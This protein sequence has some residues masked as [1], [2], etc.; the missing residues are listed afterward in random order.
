[1]KNHLRSI[2]LVFLVIVSFFNANAIDTLAINV[3]VYACKPDSGDC[4]FIVWQNHLSNISND[5]IR[6]T[7]PLYIIVLYNV[8][9]PSG[10]ALSPLILIGNEKPREWGGGESYLF[11]KVYCD[12]VL[13]S[14]VGKTVMI[15]PAYPQD[16]VQRGLFPDSATISSLKSTVKQGVSFLPSLRGLFATSSQPCGDYPC[17]SLTVRKILDLNGLDTVKVGSVSSSANGR[18]SSLFLGYSSTGR[19]LPK[20]LTYIPPEI[21]TLSSLKSLFLDGNEL[22]GLPDSIVHLHNLVFLSI[23]NNRVTSLPD[24]I[25]KLDSIRCIYIEN[26]EICSLSTAI[27]EWIENI[28]KITYC[29]RWEPAWPQSQRCTQTSNRFSFS[30]QRFTQSIQILRQRNGTVVCRVSYPHATKISLEVF[31]CKGRKLYDLLNSPVLS[32]GTST[33]LLNTK[34]YRSGAYVLRF[35]IDG[36][37]STTRLLNISR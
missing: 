17:D 18:I 19:P 37:T 2:A 30:G 29:Q 23:A 14:F 32:S 3:K 12:S 5:S 7:Y 34:Q 27:A 20:K 13:Q 15:L 28:L 36:N 8:Q 24:S 1:M 33:I 31:D 25:V 9:K 16:P 11:S 26:N 6:A 21:G 4:A 10:Y 35:T 22:T